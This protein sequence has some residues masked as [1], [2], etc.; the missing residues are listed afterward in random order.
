M[1]GLADLLM[2]AYGVGNI[3][4]TGPD[5]TLALVDEHAQRDAT[6]TTVGVGEFGNYNDVM[7]EAVANRGAGACHYRR[8]GGP[9]GEFLL[10]NAE[11]VFREVARDARIQVECNSDVAR[12]YRLIGYPNRAAA[13]DDFREDAPDCSELGLARD[14]AALYEL[15]LEV[16][17]ADDAGVSRSAMVPGMS[18]VFMLSR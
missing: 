6:V 2:P 12:Q 13:D 15:R 17:V 5:S 3:G 11:L 8:G 16:G 9:A 10:E 14:G 1:V 7:L 18:T 4:A